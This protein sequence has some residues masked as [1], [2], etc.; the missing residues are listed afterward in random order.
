MEAFTNHSSQWSGELVLPIQAAVD[1]SFIPIELDHPDPFGV[2]VMLM[3]EDGYRI[4]LT[5][6]FAR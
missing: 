4:S 3:E 6:A 2:A 5:E 1:F